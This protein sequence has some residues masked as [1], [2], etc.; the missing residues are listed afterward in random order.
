MCCIE[1]FEV[2]LEKRLKPGRWVEIRR[3]YFLLLFWI[4]G[5]VLKRDFWS[6][7]CV[8]NL[9]LSLAFISLTTCWGND[10]SYFVQ[11]KSFLSLSFPL[12]FL[13]FPPFLPPSSSFILSLP[14]FLLFSLPSTC[15]PFFS[16]HSNIHN[17]AK[18]VNSNILCDSWFG[19]LRFATWGQWLMS[20]LIPFCHELL[21]ERLILEDSL[22]E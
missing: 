15:F 2:L 7:T 9:A 22:A 10:W 18:V 20:G 12:P 21:L 13:S 8:N 3:L 16:N 1:N 17:L 5:D 19:I 4:H 14:P 11:Y 6:I